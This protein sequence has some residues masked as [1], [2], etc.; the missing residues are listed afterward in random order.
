[1][2]FKDLFLI[3]FRNLKDIKIEFSN[4]LNIFFGDNGQGKSNLLE[5]LYIITNGD[6][7]RYNDNSSLI[8][9]ESAQASIRANIIKN[10]LDY[11]IKVLID[12]RIKT[13]YLNEKRISSS[14]LKKNLYSII[15]SPESLAAIKEGSEQRRDLIDEVVTSS[16]LSSVQILND[17]KRLLR[18]R[19]KVFKDYKVEIINFN[20]AQDIIESLNPLFLE[21]A[22]KYVF[23]RIEAIKKITSTFSYI[24]KEIT[25]NQN[26]DISVEYWASDQ[27]MN[28]FTYENIYDAL[29]KRLSE[30]SKAE[31]SS[32]VS[33]VGPHKHDVKFI[34]NQNDSRFFCSQGQQRA[35]ILAFKI[36]QIV[37]HKEVQGEYPVLMLDDVL[38]ELDLTRRSFLVKFLH[39][40]NTQTFITTTDLSLSQDF[41]LD[42]LKTFKV[43]KGIVEK[44]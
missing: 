33:L 10:N 5:A 14:Q 8:N 20:Q 38:S 13:F 22:A 43:N 24:L 30:L 29:S 6:S 27:K 39:E 28:N 4:G 19:N 42:N 16:D 34:Y 44:L 37:Y 12:K 35:I 31:Y 1:M 11:E 17:Y 18:S 32:G 2:F 15:F 41:S 7:F 26:V 3:N 9:H 40:I 36:A 25:G 23:L 21:K